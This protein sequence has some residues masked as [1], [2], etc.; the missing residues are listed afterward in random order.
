MNVKITLT[1]EDGTET[2]KEGI[3]I[4]GCLITARDE[5]SCD[6]TKIIHG[7]LDP[8]STHLTIRTLQ[9]I[10][11]FLYEEFPDAY[12]FAEIEEIRSLMEGE[13]ECQELK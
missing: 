12:E 10:I 7:K 4:I 3:A 9:K 13:K 2:V 11:N 8:Y 1:Q 6:G 5:M